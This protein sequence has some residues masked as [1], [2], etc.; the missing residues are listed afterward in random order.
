MSDAGSAAPDVQASLTDAVNPDVGTAR[1]R[2]SLQPTTNPD[3]AGDNG[4][5]G[6]AVPTETSR[7][8]G[9]P[10]PDDRAA[11]SDPG[12]DS[13]G[14]STGDPADGGEQTMFDGFDR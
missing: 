6:P 1:F 11:V 13:D 5:E 12:G 4:T 9:E 2:R 14:A 3:D 7:R 8:T 10:S